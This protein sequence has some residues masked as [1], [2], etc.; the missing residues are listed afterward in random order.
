[1]K[2][3]ISPIFANIFL[4]YNGEIYNYIKLKNELI[5][6]GYKFKTSSDTEVIIY[7]FEKFELI[8]SKN[9]Q[10]FLQFLC[11]MIIKKNCILLGI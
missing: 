10:E 5:K 11:G 3:Q 4:S 9:Y 8:H 2:D 7:L 1:M 6:D